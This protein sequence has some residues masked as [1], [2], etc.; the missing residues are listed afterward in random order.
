MWYV[1]IAGAPLSESHEMKH[2]N[3]NA[4]GEKSQILSILTSIDTLNTQPSLTEEE[5]A[6]VILAGRVN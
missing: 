6:F 5:L 4:S 2:E 3:F 1:Q